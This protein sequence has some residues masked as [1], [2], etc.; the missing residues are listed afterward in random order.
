VESGELRATVEE[1]THPAPGLWEFCT[2]SE[3]VII[4]AKDTGDQ[5]VIGHR[6]SREG[7]VFT[8]DGLD[9]K[10]ILHENVVYFPV[11]TG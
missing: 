10:W 6:H 7:R 3:L 2:A 4:R 5:L 8:R 9:P 1:L 11:A